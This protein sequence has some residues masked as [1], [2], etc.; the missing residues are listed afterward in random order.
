MG[1]AAV[2]VSG[3]AGESARTAL[4]RATAPNHERVDRLFSRA[5]LSTAN[6]YSRFLLAQARA[7][8]PVEAALTQAHATQVL[9]DWAARRREHQLGADLAALGLVAPEANVT[10]GFDSDEAVLGGVYVLEGSRLGGALLKKQVPP[11]LPTAFLGA[12][13]AVG[14]RRLLALMEVR[15]VKPAQRERAIEAA[16]NVFSLFE[17]AAAAL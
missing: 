2:I 1:S 5:D 17:A 14:W 3:P 6:G 12:S 9:G 16:V 7:H 8:L 10:I 15:L 4:R 11:A 13:D